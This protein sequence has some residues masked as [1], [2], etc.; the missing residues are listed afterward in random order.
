M[1]DFTLHELHCFKAV[2]CEGSLHAAAK[3]LNR[4]HPAVHSAL[5]G[6][7]SRLGFTLFDRSGY[8]VSLTPSGTAFLARVNELLAEADRLQRFSASLQQGE[9]SDLHVV[10]GDVC[11]TRQAARLLKRFFDHCP[12]TRLHLH[13]ESL[14]GPWERLL[15]DDADL[16]LHHVEE[17]ESRFECIELFNVTL[18]PV[19][20]PNF[21]PFP[22]TRDIQLNQLKQQVQCIIRDS[23]KR[24]KRDY[25]LVEGAHSWTVADQ[26]TKKELV[27]M[28]MGWGHLPLHLIENELADGTLLSIEGD[29]IKRY[30]RQICAARLN[31]KAVGPIAQRLWEYLHA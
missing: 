26:V 7:E 11:P 22:I 6:L 14:S 10:V 3:I 31:D 29:H 5:K 25:F 27:V 18:V 24:T 21:L 8:R 9:E 19:V 4:T 28:G 2:A 13:F 16:I 20:A 17:S 1:L 15:D 23:A 12:Q 30:Q